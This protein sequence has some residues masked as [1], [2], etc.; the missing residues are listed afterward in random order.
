VGDG[1]VT[2][3]ILAIVAL[4]EGIRVVPRGAIV[5]ER[6]R[7]RWRIA[8]IFELGSGMHLVSWCIPWT[9]PAVVTEADVEPGEA[10][11]R[12]AALPERIALVDRHVTALRIVGAL[13]L[14]VLIAGLLYA[15]SH[16]SGI[17]LLAALAVLLA[18]S[19]AQALL[20]RSALAR[21]GESHRTTDALR[22]LWPFSGPRAPQLV[23]ERAIAGVPPLLAARTLVEQ[24]EMLRSMR[25]RV[26]DAVRGEH[27]AESAE[28][29]ALYDRADL[30]R[31][32]ATPVA[33]DGEPFCPRC[34]SIYRAGSSLCG[35]CD[36]IALVVKTYRRE[37]LDRE[38]AN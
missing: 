23:L 1:V 20:T 4:S 18:L 30:E 16:W 10:R 8:H 15:A 7:G 6:P 2:A 25:E 17:G 13:I 37:L 12:A 22:M 35:D 31:F 28:L 19:I 33:G 27:D 34:A 5:L 21:L 36:G 26:F 11:S 24:G 38:K 29:L 32:L 3:G 9:L 14:I